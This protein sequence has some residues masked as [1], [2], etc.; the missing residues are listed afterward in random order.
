MSE[1]SE[2]TTDC[3]T[4]WIKIKL[5][6]NKDLL[7]GS[8]YMPHRSSRD[9]SELEKSLNTACT[10]RSQKNI[11]LAGD[12]QLPRHPLGNGISGPPRCRPKHPASLS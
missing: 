2:M 12:F 7:F 3:E 6:G 1:V 11:I 9:I 8:F 10:G 5:A 4:V